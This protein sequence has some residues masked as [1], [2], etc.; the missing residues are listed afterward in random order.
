MKMQDAYNPLFIRSTL[1][2]PT[3]HGKPGQKKKANNLNQLKRALFS[4]LIIILGAN[5]SFAQSLS[6]TYTVGAGGDYTSLTLAVADVKANGMAGP[7]VFSLLNGTYNEQVVLEQYIGGSAVNTL[8]IESQGGNAEDVTIFWQASSDDDNYVIRL[9]GARHIVIRNVTLQATGEAFAHTI[10]GVSALE[11]ILV[12]SCRLMSPSVDPFAASKENVNLLPL[13]SSGIRLVNNV[14]SGGTFGINYVGGSSTAFRAPGVEITGNDIS[15]VRN[16]GIYVQRTDGAVVA[17]NTIAM[18]EDITSNNVAVILTDFSGAGM[19][20]ANRISGSGVSLSNLDSDASDPCIIANNFI[21]VHSG[22][23]MVFTGLNTNLRVYH[24]SVNNLGGGAA[25]YYNGSSSSNNAFINNNF[26]STTGYAVHL[27]SSSGGFEISDY[28]NLYASGERFGRWVN[29]NAY[30]MIEWRALSGLDQNSV[31][32]DPAYASYKELYAS[33]PTLAEAG[34]FLSD[35]PE[36]IDGV[37]R[38]ANPSIGANE[39]D[40][41]ALLPLAGTYTVDPGG[42]GTQNFLSI[43]D[44]ID[45]VLFRGVSASVSF[46]I[47]SGTYP[48]NL[49]IP[50]FFLNDPDHT[51][52][53]ESTSGLAE[54]VV[55]THSAET[56]DDNFV[57]HFNTASQVVLRN[58]SLEATGTDFTRTLTASGVISNISVE[59]CRLVSPL[60]SASNVSTNA[61]NVVV[62]P[63]ESSNVRFTDNLVTGGTVGLYIWGG[64][65]AAFRAGGIIVTGNTVTDANY[66]GIWLQRMAAAQVNGNA[67]TMYPSGHSSSEGIYLLQH[68]G[69]L[70]VTNNRVTANRWA[71][72]MTGAIGDEGDLGLVANNF[73]SNSATNAAAVYFNN[74][75][76]QRFYHNNT[77]AAGGSSG[78][79]YNATASSIG[80]VFLNNNFV[81]GTGYA[82]RVQNQNGFGSSNYN[83]L[84]TGGANLGK[85]L[86]EADSQTLL[87]WQQ[88]SGNDGNSFSIDPEYAS[89]TELYA[90]AG[91]LA[92]AGTPLAD[93]TTDI[94]GEQRKPSPS[95]GANEYGEFEA[96]S[97]AGVYSIN[98]AGSGDRNFASFLLAVQ[99]MIDRGISD[100]VIFQVAAGTYEEQVEIPPIIGASPEKTV[101]FESEGGVAEDVVLR[102]A[103]T[104]TG[105]NFVLL[106]NGASHIA[107]RNLTVEATGLSFGRTILAQGA[108]SNIL[109]EGCRLLTPDTETANANKNNLVF[110]VSAS[111]KVRIMDNEVLGGS[112][113]IHYI[114]GSSI[115]YRAEEVEITGN[116]IQAFSRGITLQRAMS[117]VVSNNTIV[118]SDTPTSSD[119]MVLSL[120]DGAIRVTGN[121]VSQVRRWGIYLST[122]KASPSAPGLIANNFLS[123]RSGNSG[124]INMHHVSHQRVYYNSLNARGTAVYY[125]GIDGVAGNE[126]ANNNFSSTSYSYW[127]ANETGFES[128]DFNNLYT[129]GPTV[130]IWTGTSIGSLDEYVALTGFDANSIGFNPQFV[131]ESD[132]YATAPALA[133]AGTPLAEVSTDIDG[134]PRK[135]TPSI[136]ANEYDADPLVPL[137]GIYTINPAGA[138]DRNFVSLYDAMDA[139]LENGIAAAVTFRIATG[140][141]QGQFEIPSV[142]GSS[143]VNTITFESESGIAED[144]VITADATQDDNYVVF[145]R[146]ASNLVLR[147]LTIQSV[148]TTYSRT[149]FSQNQLHNVLIEYCRFIAPQTTSTTILT[150]NIV[151]TPSTSSDFRFIDNVIS[152]GSTALYFYGGNSGS[153]RAPGVEIRG[154]TMSVGYQGMQLLRFESILIEGNLVGLASNSSIYSIGI[155]LGN[156]D[157]AQQIVGNRIYNAR[158]YGLYLSNNT[159]EVGSPGLVANNFVSGIGND[160]VIHLVNSNTN[161]LIYHN[162]VNNSGTTG[163]AFYYSGGSQA[164]GNRVMNNVFRAGPG[165]AIRVAGA[166]GLAQSDFNNLYTTSANLG[167]WLGT[168][169]AGLADWQTASGHDANSLNLDPKYVSTADLTP[170]EMA[171]AGEGTDLTAVV[172]DDIFGNPRTAPVSIGAVELQ[173]DV[174]VD[175]AVTAIQS[176]VSDCFLTENEEVVVDLTNNG[177]GLVSG[178]EVAYTV[179]DGAPVV[180]TTPGGFTIA[181]GQ[182]LPYT[183]A[184]T[185]DLSGKGDYT[186]LVY[187]LQDDAD[188]SNNELE[189]GITHYPDLVVEISDSQ[190]ICQGQSV[191]LTASGGTAYL[192][193]TG[194]TEASIVVSPAV[195]TVYTVVVSNEEG[196][197]AEAAVTLTVKDPPLVEFVGD[198]GYSDSFVAPWIGTEETEFTFRVKYTEPDGVFPA[199][200]YPRVELDSNNN[201]EVTDPTDVVVVMTEEDPTDTDVTNGKIYLATLGGLSDQIEWRSRITV[202][203]EEGCITSTPF[204]SS[205]ILSDDL[206]D[207]AIFASDISFS[208]GSPA[209]NE[210][211]TIFARVNNLSDFPAEDF[212]VSAYIDDEQVFTTVVGLLE[213][214]SDVTLSWTAS[215]SESGFYQVKV[216]LDETEVLD[217]VNTQNNFAIRPVLAGDYELPGGIEVS[218]AP[219]K[220]G[221]LPGES[222]RISGYANYYGIED[223]VNPDVAGASVTVHL[224]T[225]PSR[226]VNTRS[227][228]TYDAYFIAPLTPGQYLVTG[229]ITDFTLSAEIEAFYVTVIEAPPLPDLVSSMVLDAPVILAGEPASGTAT[230]SNIGEETAYNFVFRYWSCEEVLGEVLIESLAPGESL[231]YVFS[232]SVAAVGDCFNTNTCLFGTLADATYVVNE[233]RENNNGSNQ[234]LTVLPALP[235][236]TPQR[237]N[238][239]FAFSSLVNPFNISVRVDNIGGVSAGGSFNVNVYADGNLIDT[240]VFDELGPCGTITYSVPFQPTEPRSYLISVKVDEPIGSGSIAEHN[241]ENNV[242]ERTV[243]YNELRPNLNI[244]MNG[245]SLSVNNPGVGQ[246]FNVTAFYRNNGQ[247]PVNDPY[248]I[249]W[250]LQNQD[251]TSPTT[252]R[253][254]EPL[255]VNATTSAVFQTQNDG[256]ALLNIFLDSDNEINETNESD[257]TLSVPLCH[258]FMPLQAGNIWWGGFYINTQQTFSARVR[259]L[260]LFTGQDVKVAFYVN[261]VEVGTRLISTVNPTLT[262][263]GY[264]VSI[265]YTFTQGGLHELKV[266]VDPDNDYTEC[267]EENNET[268]RVINVLSPMADL[269]VLSQYI[270]P[271]NINPD[272]NEPISVFLSFDNVGVEDAGPFKVRLTVDDVPLGVD[273]AVDGLQA[274]RLTTVAIPAQYS[275]AT[276]GT[277]VIRGIVDVENVIPETTKANNEATRAIIVGGA[278]NLLFAGLT[279]SAD[280]PF[281]GDQVTITARVLNEGQ[282]GANAQV[283]FYYISGQDTVPIQSQ[284]VSVDAQQEVETSI[285]WVVANPTFPVYARIMNSD[286][287]EY[288]LLDNDISR[289]FCQEPVVTYALSTNV[290]GQGIIARSPM[291]STYVEGTQLTLLATPAIGWEFI[292]WEGDVLGADPEVQILMDDERSVTAVFQLQE[293][294]PDPDPD[295]DTFLLTLLVDPADAGEVSGGGTYEEGELVELIATAFEGYH[296]VNWTIEVEV[297]ELGDAGELADLV[298]SDEAVFEFE[299]PAE[300]VTLTANFERIMLT[301]TASAGDGGAID[302]DGEVP[303]EYGGSQSFVITPDEGYEIENLLVNGESVGPESSYLFEDVTE[304][305]TILALFAAVDEDPDPDPDPDT[306][307]LTLLVDPEEAGEVSGGGTY[308]AGESVGLIA[309]AF[310]GYLFVNW[311]IQV[312]VGELG[313]AGELADLV[314]SDEA[315]F[316]FE[317]PAE[318]VTLTANFERIMLLISASAA[319]GGTI[320]PE[321]EVLVEYGGSQSFVITA[322]EGYKIQDVLVNGESVGPESSYLFEDVTEDQTILALFAAVDEDPDPDPDPDT[323]LLT[324]LV[325]PEEAGEVSGGGTY[326][327]GE[328]VELIATAFEGYH[329]VNWT[330]EVDES[331]DA[332]ELADLVVSDEAV[333]EF[334]MPAEDVTLTANF[335]RIMLL[336]SASAAEGGTIDP[337]GEVPVEFG[338]SQSF[339]I[340]ANEGYK[341]EDVLVNGESVGPESSY[342]FEDVTE[343]QTILA[344][345]AAVDEDTDPDPGLAYCSYSQGYWFASPDVV[346]PHDVTIGGWTFTQADGA[347]F[348]PSNTNTKR[349][350]TQYAAIVLSGVD[351][352]A[353]PDLKD[354]MEVIENYFAL[355]YPAPAS[356]DV[357]RAAGFI[358]SWIDGNH[359]DD[360]DMAGEGAVETVG[361]SGSVDATGSKLDLEVVGLLNVMTYPNP[362]QNRVSLV[363]TL[364]EDSQV[365][366]E[367]FN[368]SGS[369]IALLQEGH[370]EGLT[371][372]EIAFDSS[373]LSRGVYF[374]RITAGEFVH[375]EKVIKGL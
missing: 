141:Y 306:F 108:I 149:L 338:G 319:E 356:R 293:E 138:G 353:F 291:E 54:D 129:T 45:A 125:T 140:T 164:S 281:Q 104:E 349:A 5:L 3:R 59:G 182:T 199:D 299:M 155:N 166:V 321:G 25:L 372:H 318:D 238:A 63:T 335:E 1:N 107:L 154:N 112:T 78:F 99:A 159:A 255:A 213:P 80:N 48:G 260:G 79:H 27:I 84:Y 218:A 305:Q 122:S 269:R 144:V 89:S 242:W 111:S 20:V 227:N 337:D 50:R 18:R 151:L 7:V 294:D 207:I 256:P 324:L 39:F 115:P 271:T 102:F 28:N 339:V 221:Y 274:G 65:T 273:V 172:A 336:I 350:F 371:T 171:L 368:L 71:M 196:C 13:N 60:A 198:A 209:L 74:N 308:E 185:A 243:N 161:Q 247:A 275:S 120:C 230:V 139:M 354:A 132:L 290:V 302:P 228:G 30:S 186:L 58:L 374:F 222:I 375:H 174:V 249:S 62:D 153:Y 284:N 323:F 346:W 29:T 328:L 208:N 343:D 191:E 66:R 282:V 56:A 124:L 309:T 169:T 237:S 162:N 98:P 210:T 109:I 197:E 325:V 314:V 142:T 261:D 168:N 94:D 347:A 105:Q 233:S 187:L 52:A 345:F 296:F 106:L 147:G 57:V 81:S 240:Q 266:V 344:L 201:D 202:Q 37:I 192:W 267:N 226:T 235:D 175:I 348:W 333:F 34:V 245:I 327:E 236:L 24:N 8:T 304:D 239:P 44:A 96:Q 246:A 189:V 351:V 55:L 180:E 117:P 76:H 184:A 278:P 170:E 234:F 268:S 130:V 77:L 95:I 286:P 332:G 258:D 85:W 263:S 148:N 303:V 157:G 211:I 359:C 326:E 342:L 113:G 232:T 103:A 373:D 241:E 43:Q 316:E 244:T 264:L 12:E 70:T 38:K 100:A 91:P 32:F 160:G 287:E 121:R 330:M 178:I 355:H 295:P 33:A 47:A 317:M 277:K 181:P 165:Y 223:G 283:Q 320:D 134:L 250:T 97:L 362:F 137:E 253:V 292:R 367:V 252:D 361:G 214:K 143:L 364:S 217:E 225:R 135:A 177:T 119:G 67:V 36:D 229:S 360:M 301:I 9:D 88:A 87:A 190:V 285:Q 341:I 176:P 369:R 86:T 352:D 90:S 200:G 156:S 51:I 152:G 183:F 73:F 262:S 216:I 279:F 16:R 363:F 150:R 311:T 114:G 22:N 128:S 93:V 123:G 257:N 289:A 131:S 110:D 315:V 340:T 2:A 35:V 248:N 288:N 127:V 82:I 173:G 357:N 49:E 203:T 92:N 64:G 297:G 334:E 194:S 10:L 220:A 42:S 19:L 370:L 322:N 298:V 310:E 118:V 158:Q 254:E 193:S 31:S 224:E 365:T 15:D 366:V 14:I 146:N 219:S 231:S 133:N 61:A 251:G 358:G 145:L 259:N 272:P 276:G 265:P 163:A 126:F 69:S 21:S 46:Q 195:T 72:H 4:F 204:V 206:L 41:G 179:N 280:C 307:L 83:N 11:N 6:G 75:S 136:G 40:A 188:N 68:A 116:N 26:I 329:F 331:G 167:Q 53:F 215:F 17:G 205:P 312:E 23:G 313:D 101:T 212:V 270:S 300:D